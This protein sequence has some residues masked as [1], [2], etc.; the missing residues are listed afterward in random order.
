MVAQHDQQAA[1]AARSLGLTV[2]PVTVRRAEEFTAA[3][4]SMTTNRDQGLLVMATPFSLLHQKDIV[5]LAAKHRIVAIY[6]T[7]VWVEEGGL[8]S[9]GATREVVRLAAVLVDKI[10]RGAKPADLPVEQPTQFELVINGKTAKAL[11]LTIPP[12]LLLRAD[13][14][15]Q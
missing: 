10:L 1:E 8:V 11:G 6:D 15:I 4:Q 7:R 9:F 5:G 13:E 3:F 14:A 12:S 2:H